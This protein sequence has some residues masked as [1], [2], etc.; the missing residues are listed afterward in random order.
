MRNEPDPNAEWTLVRRQPG[1]NQPYRRRFVRSSIRQWHDPDDD[2][3]AILELSVEYD[4]V[5]P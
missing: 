3:A 5:I 4:G 2:Y 1:Q